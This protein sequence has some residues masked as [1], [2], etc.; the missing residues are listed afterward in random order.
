MGLLSPKQLAG[1]TLRRLIQENYTSQEEFA[2]DF[3]M[4]IRTVSRYINS[5]IN[6]TDTIQ[7]LA[8]FFGINFRDFFSE[9]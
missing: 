8:D 9:Q 4:E 7:E 1:N 3:G 6:K 2:Y 5:G